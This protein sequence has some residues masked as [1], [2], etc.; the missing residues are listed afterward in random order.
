MFSY[1]VPPG[2]WSASGQ[3]FKPGILKSRKDCCK[4]IF[5]NTFFKLSRYGL[6]SN[7]TCNDRMYSAVKH[8]RH[9]GI[10]LPTNLL[11]F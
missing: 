1:G 9:E 5:A 7:Y 8:I 11:N 2:T 6:V 4:H 3:R 10:V